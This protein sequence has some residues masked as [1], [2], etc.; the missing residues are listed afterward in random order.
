MNTFIKVDQ[1][2]DIIHI[3][4]KVLSNK[5]NRKLYKQNQQFF[6]EHV[7]Y[8]HNSLGYRTCEN[9]PEIYGIAFGCSHTYGQGLKVS[10]RW[11]T[12]VEQ[13]VGFDIINLG[14]CGTGINFILLNLIRL[15]TS[16]LE[17]PKFIIM[18]C[19]NTARLT[20]PR[21]FCT[22]NIIPQRKEYSSLYIDNSIEY[23]S[24]ECYNL[25]HKLCKKENIKIIDFYFW[26]SLGYKQ[27]EVV[28]YARDMAHPGIETQ[29]LIKNY[30]M[31]NL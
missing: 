9:V 7:E 11:S 10:E 22:N 25:I 3:D 14:V 29:N 15:L 23:H 27:I 26:G 5:T 24:I 17:K 21:E 18:Q 31:S 16:T 6:D 19:P 13:E 30:I 4:K 20:L 12:L 28:D 2:S 1:G 8:K